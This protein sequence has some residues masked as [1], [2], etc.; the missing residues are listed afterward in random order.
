MRWLTAVATLVVIT[1]AMGNSL[2]ARATPDVTRTWFAPAV[3]PSDVTQTVRF[4]ATITNNPPSVTFQY[5]GVDRLMYDDGTHGDL[6]AGDGTWTAQFQTSEIT[7]VLTDAWVHHPFLGYLKPAGAGTFNVF[8]EVW[9]PAVGL[10][11]VQPGS[12]T[13]QKTDYVVNIK[14]TANEL[15]NFDTA[16]MAKRLYAVVGDHFDFINFVLVGGLRSDRHYGAVKNTV[17]GLGMSTTLDTT[18][19]YG[20]AGRLQGYVMFPMSAWYDGGGLLLRARARLVAD[21]LLH[22]VDAR[23]LV[24]RPP[25]AL[26]ARRPVSG[27]WVAGAAVQ[28]DVDAPGDDDRGGGHQRDSGGHPGAVVKGRPSAFDSR[29]STGLARWLTTSSR[30]PP[31]GRASPPAALCL[32]GGAADR[33]VRTPSAVSDSGRSVH[34]RRGDPVYAAYRLASFLVRAEDGQERLSQDHPL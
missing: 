5:V 32:A 8:A 16:T 20:S 1:W 21:V 3:V 12:S 34:R 33:R 23:L 29:P 2:T 13:A 27:G 7:A 10:A 11:S 17:G 19:S 15:V 14:A 31:G 22:R 26:G 18:T 4:E 6:V 24:A 25:A 9:T 28:P 30:A